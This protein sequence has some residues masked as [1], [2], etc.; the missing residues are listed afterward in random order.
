[1]AEARFFKDSVF[2]PLNTTFAISLKR[3]FLNLETLE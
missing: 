3:I 1:M 2:C